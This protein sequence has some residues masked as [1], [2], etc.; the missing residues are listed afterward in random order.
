MGNTSTYQRW[1]NRCSLSRERGELVY[2]R[3]ERTMSSHEST[4]TGQVCVAFKKLS[5]DL[6]L[7]VV[8]KLP[9][10]FL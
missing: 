8:R 3:A 5:E 10:I 9:I 4:G 2:Y 7:N 1:P 6:F